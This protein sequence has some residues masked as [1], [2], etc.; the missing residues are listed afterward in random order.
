MKPA[1]LEG[2]AEVPKHFLIWLGLWIAAI[3]CLLCSL[4]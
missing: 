2:T 1:T 4:A 3:A